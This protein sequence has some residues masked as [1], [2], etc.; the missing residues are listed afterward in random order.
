M[1]VPR[2]FVVPPGTH[3][4]PVG[5]EWLVLDADNRAVYRL[6]GHAAEAIT[7]IAAGEIELPPYLSDAVAVLEDRGLI[8]DTA[9]YQGEFTVGRRRIIAAGLAGAVGLT[10]LGLP[11]AAAAQSPAFLTT[12]GSPDD[13]LWNDGT[14]T[15]R[16]LVYKGN[17]TFTTTPVTKQLQ[18]MIVGG[19]GGGG[20]GNAL[21]GGN[22]VK[23]GG[24]GGG[25]GIDFEI[26]TPSASTTYT[27]AV[28]TGGTGGSTTGP[29]A[30]TNGNNSSVTGTGLT[31]AIGYGGGRG[32]GSTAAGA[33]GNGGASTGSGGGGSVLPGGNGAAAAPGSASTQTTALPPVGE[34]NSIQGQAGGN[35]GFTKGDNPSNS[36]GG[37]GGFGLAGGNAVAGQAGAGGA[38]FTGSFGYRS[39]PGDPQ[40]GTN[41]TVAGGGGGGCA[42]SGAGSDGGGTGVTS[43]TPNAGA[44]NRG[45]GGGGSRDGNGGNGGSGVV[46]VRYRL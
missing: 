21:T 8:V 1:S 28:G 32:G 4:E 12:T 45:G 25:G 41:V 37:G 11:R 13:Y 43:G 17:G 46:V 42:V 30:A 34:Q 19:G 15:W 27:V 24:G 33:T 10:V 2:T 29:T 20:G 22:E 23:G 31:A 39:L 7:R 6:T 44:T 35:A 14:N 40:N 26:F 16:V 38:G 3:L 18:L 9:F 36:G 5:S